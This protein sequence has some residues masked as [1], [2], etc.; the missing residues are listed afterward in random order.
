MKPEEFKKA[1]ELEQEIAGH[2]NNLA[3]AQDI[4]TMKIE[5]IQS[6]RIEIFP[7]SGNNTRFVYMNEVEFQKLIIAT[8][9]KYIQDKINVL[10]GQF[11]ALLKG[12]TE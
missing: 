6:F 11:D 2:K 1:K 9:K 3:W 4:D 10:Q 12:G 5:D 7:V 8:A